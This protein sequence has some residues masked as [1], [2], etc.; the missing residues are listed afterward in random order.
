M[1]RG[2]TSL[3]FNYLDIF[4]FFRVKNSL[5]FYLL[6]NSTIQVKNTHIRHIYTSSLGSYVLMGYVS[7][8]VRNE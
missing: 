1:I 8:K 3:Y 6:R 4:V 2:I 7:S 5:S